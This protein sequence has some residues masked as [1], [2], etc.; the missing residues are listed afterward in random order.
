[1]PPWIKPLIRLQG[2]MLKD[3]LNEESDQVYYPQQN[4]TSITTYSYGGMLLQ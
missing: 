1:M 2:D 3:A 4:G